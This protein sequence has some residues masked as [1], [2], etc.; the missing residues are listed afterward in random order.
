MSKI[1]VRVK[2]KIFYSAACV[3]KRMFDSVSK[4]GCIFNCRMRAP[5]DYR[6]RIRIL[7]PATILFI[8]DPLDINQAYFECQPM[9]PLQLK[10]G[11]Q[12]ISFRDRRVFG[13]DDWG[14][15]GCYTWDAAIIKLTNHWLESHWIAGRFI[16]HDPDRWPNRW[17]EG[18]TAFA[19]YNSFSHLPFLLDVFY[20][21]KQDDRGMTSGEKGTGNL[22]S[23]SIGFW[24]NGKWQAWE[25]GVTAVAQ[26][27]KWGAD[28]IQAYGSV[29]SLAYQ[30]QIRWQTLLKVQGI[31]GSGD[32]NPTDGIHGTF[33]GVF[34]GAGTDLYGWM[35]MFFW[36]NLRE[37]R[38]DLKLTP[39]KSVGFKRRVSLFCIRPSQ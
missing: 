20:V 32:R 15:T 27:G 8:H 6:S 13:P 9:K 16:L 22:T 21:F 3:W 35:N 4:R 2:P 29:G 37:Y 19:S 5:S 28:D 24:L 26:L 38:L 39:A 25:Y 34:G 12:A 10:I 11:R 31:I 36:Q 17:A 18:P 7:P 1:S 23:H 33:D 30:W 14:N